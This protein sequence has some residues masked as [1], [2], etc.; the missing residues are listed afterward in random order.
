M[1]GAARGQVEKLIRDYLKEAKLMQ[2]ATCAGD[3]PWVAS[4]WFS[5][6]EDLNLYFMSRNDRRH[7]CELRDNPRVAGGIAHPPFEKPG[8]KV[9]GLAF[10]GRAEEA[11]GP[12]SKAAYAY[13]R[14]RWSQALG[15]V[16]PGGV[17]GDF[18]RARV[19]RITPSLYVL[20][21]EVNFPEQ[22]RQEFPLG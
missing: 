11:G 17:A 4:V 15:R 21:D 8:G 18:T 7:C 2:L 14:K 12:L 22:P 13:Y 3:Q 9:R 5:S 10:Q 6:D 19:Y 20:Y 1:P 16:K